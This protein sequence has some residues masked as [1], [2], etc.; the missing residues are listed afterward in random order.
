MQFAVWALAANL[1]PARRTA[2]GIGGD[3]ERRECIE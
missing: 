2:T 1:L 3:G